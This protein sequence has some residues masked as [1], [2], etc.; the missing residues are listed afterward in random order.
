MPPWTGAGALH[1]RHPHRIA[2]QKVRYLTITRDDGRI[3]VRFKDEAARDEAE[4]II[5]ASS[6]T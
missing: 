5:R 2:Q 4:K 6:A 3:A 1:R